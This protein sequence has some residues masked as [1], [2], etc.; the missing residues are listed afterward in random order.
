MG[1]AGKLAVTHHDMPQAVVRSVEEY[2]S[3]A[4]AL[5]QAA[6]CGDSLPDTLRRHFDDRL[7]ALQATDVQQPLCSDL[8]LRPVVARAALGML[9]PAGGL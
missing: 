9:A 4:T 3:V 2:V 7:A 5:R 8:V 6:E 1:R